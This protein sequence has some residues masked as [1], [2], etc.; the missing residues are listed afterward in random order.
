LCL[1]RLQP[2]YLETQQIVATEEGM[3]VN[4][5]ATIAWNDTRLFAIIVP[6]RRN[7]SVSF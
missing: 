2:Q 1:T 4:D 7:P 6:R 5:I 3:K